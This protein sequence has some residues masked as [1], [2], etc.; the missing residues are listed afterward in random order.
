MPIDDL[1]LPLPDEEPSDDLPPE[2]QPSGIRCPKCRHLNPI[3]RITCERCQAKLPRPEDARRPDRT[4]KRPNLIVGWALI[5]F[6]YIIFSVV[7]YATIVVTAENINPLDVL[8]LVASFIGLIIGLVIVVGVWRLERWARIP[9]LL[10]HIVLL[11]LTIAGL[12][13]GSD[14]SD[15]D[16]GTTISPSGTVSE[17]NNV[18]EGADVCGTIFWIGLNLGFMY[19]FAKNERVFKQRR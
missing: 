11:A 6:S 13:F 4:F 18:V 10:L 17:A 15:E 1:I 3:H 14:S 8:L 12:I 16:T 9:A 19:W 2:D 5:T 7:S